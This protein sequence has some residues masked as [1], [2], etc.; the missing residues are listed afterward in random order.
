MS[1]ALPPLIGALLEPRCYPEPPAKVD[2]VETHASWLLIAGNFV[3]KIKKPVVLP[4]LDYG[5]LERRLACCTAELQLNR[6]F[7]PDLY[8]EVVSIVD[9]GG[10]P[11][12]GGSGRILEYAVKMRRFAESG[13][14]DRLCVHHHLHPQHVSE[15][16]TRIAAFHQAAAVAPPASDFGRPERVRSQVLDNLSTLEAL[17]PDGPI[18]AQLTL[19][20]AWSLRNSDRLVPQLAARRAAGRIRECHGD[21]HLG[22]LV[23]IGSRVRLFDC[24]EFSEDLRWIDVASEIAF[25]YIDLLSHQQPAL[26]GWFINEWLSASGDYAALAVLRYYA[27]YRALVRAKIAAIRA[28]QA[29]GDFSTAGHYLALGIHLTQARAKR[30]IITH[31]LAG[32]GKSRAARQ[33]VLQDTAGST[34]RLRSDVERKRLFGLAPTADSKSPV[35]RGIYSPEASEQTYSRLHKLASEAL[36]GGWSVVVD[37]AFLQ[38]SWREDF[39]DLAKRAEVPFHIVAPQASH[40][41]LRARLRRRNARGHDPSEATPAV[42]ERQMACVDALTADERQHLL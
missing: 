9:Q 32:C 8:L 28:A 16:G 7:A 36:A 20:S 5:T 17:L 21:L 33:L 31:G 42:L 4:F 38:H 13:R 11:V 12:V 19:L 22:N 25:T 14:L 6:R 15:L 35:D 30:L 40:A 10:R 18:Q 34:I 29:S 41:Q 23:L 24:I 26:A 27:V 37:A 3:Y 2:L 1:A 39:R